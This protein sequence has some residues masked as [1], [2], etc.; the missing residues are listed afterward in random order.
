LRHFLIASAAALI[1]A[2]VLLAIIWHREARDQAIT[3]AE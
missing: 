1:I 2:T 3:V